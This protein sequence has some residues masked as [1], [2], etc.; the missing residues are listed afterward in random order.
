M[1]KYYNEDYE[2]IEAF[3]KE[4]LEAEVKKQVAKIEAQI[5]SK[6]E[7][8]AKIAAERDE[9][10]EKLTKRSEEYKNLKKALDEKE[11]ALSTIEADRKATYE[12]L[13]DDMITKAAGDDKEYAEVLRAQYD[14]VGKE[15]LNPTE[16]ESA[17]KEAHVLSL[18]QMNREFTAFSMGSGATGQPPVVNANQDGAA[19]TDTDAGKATLDVV[20]AAVGQAAPAI[21]ND[22]NR[23]IY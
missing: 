8:I 1:A 12:K 19:F 13:R 5:K 14:R 9:K 2:P 4:E 6:D 21:T 22:P 17:L 3:S 23:V 10:D 16:I 15:T 18:N 20:K 7:E 11:G